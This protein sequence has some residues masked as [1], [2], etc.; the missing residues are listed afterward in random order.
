MGSAYVDAYNSRPSLNV[1]TERNRRHT[2]LSFVEAV[3][4]DSAPTVEELLPAYRVAGDGF[5]GKMKA[6]F[7]IL[8]DDVAVKQPQR[9]GIQK[10]KKRQ[11][12]G[13]STV[14]T[15]KKALPSTQ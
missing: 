3:G 12:S 2:T 7:I 13:D 8:D 11:A 9:A 15:K 4:Q 6:L 1:R 5:I 10:K 14:E